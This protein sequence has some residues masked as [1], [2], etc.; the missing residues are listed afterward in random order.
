MHRFKLRP[1]RSAML[2]A[3]VAGP[4]AAGPGISLL[5]T[6]ALALLKADQPARVAKAQTHLETLKADLGLD[7]R[8]G[9]QA[10]RPGTTPEG[11]TVVR[12][13]Q[14]H[15]G[16]R[17]WSG[18]AIVHV[19]ATGE[20]KAYT[21][22]LLPGVTLQGAPKLEAAQAQALVLRALAPKGP[23]TLAPTVE[24]VVFPSR[25]TGGVVLAQDAAR[26]RMVVDPELSV[27]AKAP[28]APFVWAY[29]VKV[30]LRSPQDGLKDYTFIVDA[31][32][33]AILRKTREL[34]VAGSGRPTALTAPAPLRSLRAGLAAPSPAVGTG[35]TLYSGTVSLPTTDMGDGTFALIDTTRGTVPNP[36]TDYFFP[37]TP[38]GLHVSYDTELSSEPGWVL[39]RPYMG[40]NTTNT[41]GDGQPFN[42]TGLAWLADPLGNNSYEDA[43]SAHGET[44]AADALHGM[45]ASWDFYQKLFGRNG[46]DDQGTSIM[47]SV[48][49][50]TFDMTTGDQFD[51]TAWAYADPYRGII[52]L[53]DGTTDTTTG[54]DGNLPWTEPDLVGRTMSN[55]MIQASSLVGSGWWG[56]STALMFG[57]SD[58]F[59]KMIEA[60]AQRPAGQD[61][62]VPE[63]ATPAD[64]ATWQ[65][66]RRA[67]KG[68]PLAHFVKPSLDGKSADAWYDGI[69]VTYHGYASGPLRRM[70][71]FLAQGASSTPSSN[72]Y[73]PFL[74]GGMTGLGNDKATKI[75]YK[76]VTEFLTQGSNYADCR[77]AAILAAHELFPEGGLAEA[78]VA[79]A[80]A[81]I[82]IG[83]APGQ[84]ARVKVSFPQVHADP[85]LFNNYSSYYPDRYAKIQIVPCQAQ[86]KL[87]C[88]VENTANT[89]LTWSLGDPTTDMYGDDLTTTIGGSITPEGVWTTPLMT[90]NGG[91]PWVVKATSQADPLQFAKGRVLALPMDADLDAET[92]A[93][94]LGALAMSF[95]LPNDKVVYPM[96]AVWNNYG[97]PQDLDFAVLLE[98][99]GNAFPAQ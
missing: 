75:W 44:V 93:L 79:K 27:L 60:Y 1:H 53:G 86:V 58:I 83:S 22:S 10:H 77:D 57:T 9:F 59:G 43:T 65:I 48:H 67:G 69:E 2:L 24:P 91:G 17:V 96:A 85:G 8:A 68:T 63:F 33:G 4:L 81:A 88:L 66:G 76:A 82:N 64:A 40:L 21:R 89:A 18:E 97:A 51:M 55:L 5:R 56:E 26:G 7:A 16:V 92:D 29:E 80:F 38:A 19:A 46:V 25:L 41:W 23:L 6:E 45:A 35:N 74:P 50:M 3:L 78:A 70:F 15:Q 94:D 72:A 84:P 47:G 73:S 71:Y 99:L 90:N 13:H 95:G 62:A 87:K 37:G 49:R 12:F 39:P 31:T 30:H 98:G 11:R 20:V 34:S 14:L 52:A 42:G 54:T 32:T 36:M 61:D 28:A